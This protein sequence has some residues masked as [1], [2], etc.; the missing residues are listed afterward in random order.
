M[1]LGGRLPLS[2]KHREEVFSS[3]FF[4]TKMNYIHMNPVRAGLVEKE[5]E[6]LLSSA[7]A[8]YGIREGR[9]EPSRF[10]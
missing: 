1:V 8:I 10:G 6:Y 9:L 4:D 5:E 7:G 3:D 2:G